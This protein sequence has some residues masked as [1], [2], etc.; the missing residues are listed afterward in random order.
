MPYR[1]MLYTLFAVALSLLMV[2]MWVRAVRPLLHRSNEA[3]TLHVP[4][5]DGWKAVEAAHEEAGILRHPNR[6]LKKFINGVSLLYLL[7][8]CALFI[9]GLFATF[10]EW[11]RLQT[12]EGKSRKHNRTKYVDAWKIAGERAQPDPPA[13]EPPGH[14]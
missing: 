6:A 9:V 5:T 8:I 3:E 11:V 1:G 12:I 7:L 4:K 2:G 14:V 13:P 10:R